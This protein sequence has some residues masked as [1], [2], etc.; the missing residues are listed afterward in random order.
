MA[1]RSGDDDDH[2]VDDGASRGGDRRVS[3][4][5]ATGVAR[6]EARDVCGGEDGERMWTDRAGRHQVECNASGAGP[7]HSGTN[8]KIPRGADREQEDEVGKPTAHGKAWGQG[9][10]QERRRHKK[11]DS[12][13][14]P[15][16]GRKSVI[17]RTR[18]RFA[19]S[20]TQAMRASS[21]VE[22]GWYVTLLTSPTTRPRGYSPPTPLVSAQSP[23]EAVAPK[24][25]STCIGRAPGPPDTVPCRPDW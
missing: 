24:A 13:R 23:C 22:D 25:C 20:F 15:H 11:N 12:G 16:D 21:E 4:L 6:P 5:V 9:D 3:R 19:G 1:E 10:L 17:T 7:R 14:S 2:R 18:A 8:A